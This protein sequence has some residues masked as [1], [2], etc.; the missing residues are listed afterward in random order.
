M[1]FVLDENKLKPLHLTPSFS[2]IHANANEIRPDKKISIEDCGINQFERAGFFIKD[3]KTN[4]DEYISSMQPSKIIKKEIFIKKSKADISIKK[5]IIL[6]T[7]KNEADYPKYIFY[8]FDMSEK[9]KIQIQRD[10]RPFNSIKSAEITMDSYMQKNIK[11][12]W[13]KYNS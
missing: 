9:R 7:R 11:K 3:V 10:V 4:P 6:E 12:G 13:E 2:I 8:Y 1:A 5:F